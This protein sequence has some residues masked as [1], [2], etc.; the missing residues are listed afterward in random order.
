MASR[1]KRRCE[2]GQDLAEFA[3]ITPLLMLILLGIIEF[4]LVVFCYNSISN[5]AREGARYGTVHPTDTVGIQAAALHSMTGLASIPTTPSVTYDADAN[6]IRV[7]ID[8]PYQMITAPMLRVLRVVGLSGV[9][10]LAAASTM[11]TEN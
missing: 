5:A 10:H 7:Q 2:H 1:P 6:T 8:Y 11:N 4:S 3:L 9:I